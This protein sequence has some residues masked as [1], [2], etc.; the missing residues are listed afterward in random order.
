M[1][2]RVYRARNALAPP[3]QDY[4]QRSD[5]SPSLVLWVV[6]Q[7]QVAPELTGQS[8]FLSLEWIIVRVITRRSAPYRVSL[9]RI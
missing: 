6:C 1:T 3:I 5:V 4:S 7:P 9:A 2:Q 8:D